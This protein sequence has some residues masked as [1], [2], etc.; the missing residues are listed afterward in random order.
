MFT[1][2]NGRIVI[3]RIKENNPAKISKEIIRN[4]NEF[5]EKLIHLPQND[6]GNA[7]RFLLFCRDF[8]KY[9]VTLQG[10][11]L[12]NGKLWNTENS[13]DEI[14]RLAQAVMEKYYWVAKEDTTLDSSTKKTIVN[15]AKVSNN[16]KNLNDMLTL[17]KHMNYVKEMNS[18]PHLLNVQNGVVNLKTRKLMP[19][20]PKY[21]CS[22]ICICDY[23]PAAKSTRFKSFVKEITD[24]NKDLYDYLKVA[25][26]YWSTGL[27]RE[28]KFYVM[29]GNGSNGKSKYLEVIEYVLNSYANSFP[30]NAL[31]KANNDSSR[32]TPELVP[33]I[34]KRFAHTSELE[35]SNIINDA[36]IKQYTGNAHILVRKMRQEYSKLDIFFKIVIDTN[37]DPNFRRFDD[38][39][40]RRIVI[41]PFTKKFE[42]DD[43]DNDIELKLREDAQ[44]ILKWIADGAYQ[45]FKHGLHEPEIIKRETEKYCSESDS[46]QSFIDNATTLENSGITKSSVLHQAYVEYCNENSY[47]ALENKSFSQTLTRKGFEK[48]LKSSGT[49]FKGIKLV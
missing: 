44:F 18:A 12:W 49:F 42:G 28:E 2:N 35:S 43:R 30:T 41:I 32:P 7:K 23:N 24:H 27:R 26:G 11:M 9:N 13:Y 39:I 3:H 1:Y 19:H 46:V 17:V 33:L 21:G 38:A 40:K 25:A 8:V 4:D 45:Y 34:N 15:H 16:L 22:N 36:C 48:K 47:E 37:F 29:R 5:S 20:H 10:W 14:I 31:T 6:T